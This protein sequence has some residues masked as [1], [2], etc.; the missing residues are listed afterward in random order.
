M[1]GNDRERQRNRI[2]DKIINKIDVP[3][4]LALQT[5]PGPTTLLDLLKA[6]GQFS[7]ILALGKMAGWSKSQIERSFV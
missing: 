2:E 7:T 1:K 5:K 4:T 3:S 6:K